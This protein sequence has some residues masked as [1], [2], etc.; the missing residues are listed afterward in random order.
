M[1]WGYHSEKGTTSLT[2][3]W[4]VPYKSLTA[5]R[6]VLTGTGT[7]MLLHLPRAFAR[8]ATSVPVGSPCPDWIIPH[9][10][11]QQGFPGSGA[12][13]LVQYTGHAPITYW[14]SVTESPPEGCLT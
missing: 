8:A 12:D 14:V 4:F 1:P 10:S 9:S 7:K 2:D 6:P 13:L 11:L 3:V 5:T